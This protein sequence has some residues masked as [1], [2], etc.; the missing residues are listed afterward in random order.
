MS[1]LLLL[2]YGIAN[3][4]YNWSE[5][6]YKNGSSIE[7]VESEPYEANYISREE[8]KQVFE[9]YRNNKITKGEAI[10]KLKNKVFEW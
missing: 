1:V 2:S 6:T 5:P 3:I 9:D 4:N 8:Y 10:S 7:W